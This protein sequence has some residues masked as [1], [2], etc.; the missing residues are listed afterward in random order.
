MRPADHGDFPSTDRLI[1]R[2]QLSQFDRIL[3][4]GLDSASVS[5]SRWR[6]R[7]YAAAKTTHDVRRPLRRPCRS[8]ADHPGNVRFARRVQ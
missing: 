8:E 6:G 1:G 4:V 2:R 7:N 5:C 3:A